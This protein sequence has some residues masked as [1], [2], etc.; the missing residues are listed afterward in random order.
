MLLN[1]QN[2]LLTHSLAD[3]AR[4]HGVY[5]RFSTQNPLKLSLNYDQ[6]E[7]KDNDVI[8]CECRG[9]VLECQRVPQDGR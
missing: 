9:L 3:L 8:A 2:Y 7:A 5:G 4:D 6:L 1:V